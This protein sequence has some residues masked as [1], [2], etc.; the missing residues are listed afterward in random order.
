MAVKK[1]KSKLEY[2]GPVW[3]DENGKLISPGYSTYD[4]VRT[5]YDYVIFTINNKQ[6]KTPGLVEVRFKRSKNKDHKK[7]VGE[8]ATTTT[9]SGIK[10]AEIVIELTLLSP[11]HKIW[12]D[13]YMP[14]LFPKPGKS[15]KE[16]TF[17]VK[18]PLF[19]PT[20][21]NIKAVV[22]TGFEGPMRHTDPRAKM[23][24]IE[25]TEWLPQTTKPAGGTAPPPSLAAEVSEATIGLQSL[26]GNALA[27]KTK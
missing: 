25:C 16:L 24:R 23:F 12:L 10:A 4:S 9:T 13:T 3:E 26:P 5:I 7:P 18:H 21:G 27:S 19:S 1:S 6:V 20:S 14:I 17:K 8:D 15:K 2:W 11:D 22:I